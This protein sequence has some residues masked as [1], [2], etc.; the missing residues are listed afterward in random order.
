VRRKLARLRQF[1]CQMPLGEPLQPER[2]EPHL[3]AELAQARELPAHAGPAIAQ[4]PAGRAPAQQP[5]R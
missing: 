5:I 2:D 1:G 3:S 4:P